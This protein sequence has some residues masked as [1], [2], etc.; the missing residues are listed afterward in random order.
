ML[1]IKNLFNSNG[2]IQLPTGKFSLIN[3]NLFGS[4]ITPIVPQEDTSSISNIAIPKFNITFAKYFTINLATEWSNITQ[5]LK[6]ES[7]DSYVQSSIELSKPDY[8]RKDY[9]WQLQTDS[10]KFS[11][12]IK[13]EHSCIKLSHKIYV[14]TGHKTLETPKNYELNINS[15]VFKSGFLSKNFRPLPSS[16]NLEDVMLD[17]CYKIQVIEEKPDFIF[18][19][20]RI[21]SEEYKPTFRTKFEH[22]YMEPDLL[23]RRRSTYQKPIMYQI[24]KLGKL[25]VSSKVIVKNVEYKVAYNEI[26]PVIFFPKA[27]EIPVTRQLRQ[28]AWANESAKNMNEFAPFKM[29]I[30]PLKVLSDKSSPFNTIIPPI[31]HHYTKYFESEFENLKVNMLV[32]APKKLAFAKDYLKYPSLPL[33]GA[34]IVKKIGID[35]EIEFR[36]KTEFC[37]ESTF[38]SE[39]IPPDIF[40]EKMRFRSEKFFSYDWNIPSNEIITFNTD[41]KMITPL[42]IPTII[43]HNDELIIKGIAETSRK[44]KYPI[45]VKSLKL[46]NNFTDLSSKKPTY[47]FTFKLDNSEFNKL[48]V[49]KEKCLNNDNNLIQKPF[50]QEYLSPKLISR[51]ILKKLAGKLPTPKL[52]RGKFFVIPEKASD[53]LYKHLIWQFS[54]EAGPA[55]C[56]FNTTITNN[57]KDVSINSFDVKYKFIPIPTNVEFLPHEDITLRLSRVFLRKPYRIQNNHIKDL[58]ALAKAQSA[59][60]SELVNS[61]NVS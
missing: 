12:F 43:H 17:Y 42:K 31:T 38:N 44:A 9:I 47:D 6:T 59:K 34:E 24:F 10:A 56:E 33:V 36:D 48:F 13:N 25:K 53:I 15:Q 37:I 28:P 20:K 58:L 5:K 41:I 35:D 46:I 4:K 2:I 50:E 57:N 21:K 27:I 60:A 3:D 45:L 14:E 22:K 18:I 23:I 26:F 29:Q 40:I 61:E 49:I 51:Y 32:N 52:G 16:L 54:R 7:P 30:S 19:E 55:L 39:L 8:H 11:I 1:E